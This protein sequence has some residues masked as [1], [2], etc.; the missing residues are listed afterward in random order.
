MSAHTQDPVDPLTDEEREMAAELEAVHEIHLAEDEETR[1]W[2][3]RNGI[4]DERLLQ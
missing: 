3:K 1:R 4:Y 2:E